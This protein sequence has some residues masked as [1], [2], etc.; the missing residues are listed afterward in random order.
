MIR[1]FALT[2]LITAA[3]HAERPVI[4]Q[5]F[6]RHFSNLNET[7]ESNGPLPRNGAGKF[8][9]IN[10]AAADAGMETEAVEASVGSTRT[11]V[12]PTIPASKAAPAN[13]AGRRAAARV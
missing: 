2:L 13:I 1:L 4:Y 6:V 10:D 5:L 11:V 9:E 8:A 3:A 7:R 12:P